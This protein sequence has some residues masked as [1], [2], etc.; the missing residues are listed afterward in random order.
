MGGQ[1]KILFREMTESF[2]FLRKVED[3]MQRNKMLVRKLI[4]GANWAKDNEGMNN[5]YDHRDKTVR[6]IL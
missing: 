4:M 3:R 2:Y 1:E 5:K 6:L